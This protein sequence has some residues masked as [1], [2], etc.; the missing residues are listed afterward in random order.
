MV[1]NNGDSNGKEHGTSNGNRAFKE[2]S[3]KTIMYS[4]SFNN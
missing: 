2:A 4:R 3:Q 1:T